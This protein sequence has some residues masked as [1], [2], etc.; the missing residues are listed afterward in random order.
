M[1]DSATEIAALLAAGVGGAAVSGFWGW[2]QKR[3]SN[4]AENQVG[5]AAILGAATRLQE[6][7]NAAAE[8]HVAGL[9]LEMDGYRSELLA[10]KL[11]IE[12][13]EGENRQRA[14]IIDSLHH[15]L[16]R[17]GI[18]WRAATAAGTVLVVGDGEPTVITGPTSPA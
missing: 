14:Q 15:L 17:Q 4:K 8:V 11:R 16:D 6:I 13:L 9:R 7:M 2:V 1:P 18:N 5:E 3:T 12:H 10:A